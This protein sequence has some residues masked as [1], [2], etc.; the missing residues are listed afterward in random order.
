MVVYA[1]DFVVCFQNKWEAERFCEQMKK[2]M[3]YFGLELQEDKSRLI[4]F[5]RFAEQ[6]AKEKG[7]KVATFDLLG[8]HITV[9][10]TRAVSSG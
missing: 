2:R 6:D 7:R 9:P 3:G 1:D 10:Q 4:K 5:D 8:S